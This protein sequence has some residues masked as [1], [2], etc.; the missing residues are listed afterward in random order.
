M[1]ATMLYTASAR[2]LSLSRSMS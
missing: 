1:Q 2:Q